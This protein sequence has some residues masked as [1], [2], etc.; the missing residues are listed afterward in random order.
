LKA[1]FVQMLKSVMMTVTCFSA[2]Y[3]ACFVLFVLL[4]LTSQVWSNT[5]PSGELNKKLRERNEDSLRIDAKNLLRKK[6]EQFMQPTDGNESS[7]D[8]NM[9]ESM[10]K[11]FTKEE[12]DII[13]KYKQSK[14]NDLPTS[15]LSSASTSDISEQQ[16]KKKKRKKNISSS[17]SSSSSQNKFLFNGLNRDYYA[18]DDYTTLIPTYYVD[19]YILALTNRRISQCLIPITYSSN[20]S[21]TSSDMPLTE[22]TI[23]FLSSK[24][25]FSFFISQKSMISS[26][27]LPIQSFAIKEL[28]YL[29]ENNA[30]E[31]FRGHELLAYH[32]F[33]EYLPVNPHFTSN[34]SNAEME[35]L[36]VLPL[37]WR[38]TM[39]ET[40]NYTYFIQYMLEIQSYLDLRDSQYLALYDVTKNNG[41]SKSLPTKFLIASTYNM[42][43]MWGSGMAS[44]QRKGPQ[45]TA[46]SSLIQNV[47]IGHYERWPQCPDL[48]RKWWKYIVELPYLPLVGHFYNFEDII[49]N[50][51]SGGGENDAGLSVNLNVET[52]NLLNPINT[53]SK[54]Q[55]LLKVKE[56]NLL[57][58]LSDM[59]NLQTNEGSGGSGGMSG[60]AG[61][62]VGASGGRGGGVVNDGSNNFMGA[63]N[64]N[65][66]QQQDGA[67]GG[68]GGGAFGAPGD[69]I[70]ENGGS[71]SAADSNSLL[72]NRRFTFLFIGNL[73]MVGPNKVCSIRSI[74]S[75]LLPRND[76]MMIHLPLHEPMP[77]NEVIDDE[78]VKKS[79]NYW[80][81]QGKTTEGDG[82][83]TNE[84]E[85]STEEE[86]Q[87][88]T[89]GVYSK[90]FNYI[91]QSI[92]CLVSTSTSYSSAFF[93]HAIAGDCI[94]IVINDWFV[95][96]FPWI[97]SY[98]TFVIRV[99]EA[100]FI[101]APNEVLNEIKGRYLPSFS[102][103]SSS[104]S[105]SSSGSVDGNVNP[106]SS[107]Y[108]LLLNNMRKAMLKMKYYLSYE[109]IPYSSSRYYKLL[110][111]DVHTY[112]HYHY[113]AQRISRGSGA[114]LKRKTGATSSSGTKVQ[115]ILPF[116]LFL[117]ELRYSGKDH[118]YYNNIPCY[119]P[120]MCSHKYAKH[121][122][123]L[124]YS[125][126]SSPAA[127][128]IF[129]STST[130]SSS[131]ASSIGKEESYDYQF[132]DSSN[133]NNQQTSGV[134]SGA[135]LY[136]KGTN[137]KTMI[138]YKRFN[139]YILEKIIQSRYSLLFSKSMIFTP[140]LSSGIVSGSGSAM[141]YSYNLSSSVSS[142]SSG[143][144]PA[145]ALSS[146]NS[147]SV[148]Y[149]V[150]VQHDGY[151]V[152]SLYFDFLYSTSGAPSSKYDYRPYLCKHNGR[153]IGIY[154]I[155]YFMQCVRVL[156]TLNPG[157][158]KGN[159]LSLINTNASEGSECKESDH[160]FL[161]FFVSFFVCL[162]SCCVGCSFLLLSFC[163]VYRFL[164]YLVSYESL[165]SII[166]SNCYQWFNRL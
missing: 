30:L 29:Y 71:T 163:F 54:Y 6:K 79:R 118:K 110:F 81:N 94:P 133:N 83:T 41:R 123:R 43:T 84:Q 22:K 158:L 62:D 127:S 89:N 142:L 52:M 134:T 130:A 66:L 120:Y 57:S 46:M 160:F 156:W 145:S 2:S 152:H 55:N 102:S 45:W 61:G 112:Y 115:T 93:Y 50:E 49:Y 39:I 7:N 10:K 26:F 69:G 99:L 103:S 146:Y 121:F 27:S 48:L 37:H 76:L 98:E 60:R 88:I 111:S 113:N 24:S 82:T 164:F 87:G 153:L 65:I 108:Y 77:G 13:R 44:Q 91:E 116:E 15:F 17:S 101:K 165:S 155:V 36:P 122:Y 42:R 40:C 144:T 31:Y 78:E 58:S 51:I 64:E 148:L 132:Y 128:S 166:S 92:F 59:S 139:N 25:V 20:F 151:Q 161:V 38:A 105:G 32:F 34:F 90:I 129:T 35:Y 3:T 114:I 1:G 157:K 117:L 119:R 147:S 19:P 124:S 86:G 104:V 56:E 96:S 107:S 106:S 131:A 28:Q 136:S 47:S 73:E 11:S 8:K 14:Q 100:D 126:S 74:L 109:T 149:S 162:V 140:S 154:K 70:G 53:F 68:G 72:Q 85:G 18:S 33:L 135:R 67:G 16:M 97:I 12:L 63:P 159:D 21:F 4:L 138:Y 141:D 137:K 75:S 23:A 125:S 95:F 143:S 9:K 5:L 80:K 150:D